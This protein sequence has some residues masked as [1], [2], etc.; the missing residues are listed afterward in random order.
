MFRVAW[1]HINRYEN[2]AEGVRRTYF[3]RR[4]LVVNILEAS[5]LSLRLF[6]DDFTVPAVKTARARDRVLGRKPNLLRSQSDVQCRLGFVWSYGM[7]PI[8]NP[9]QYL[10]L[11]SR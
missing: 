5:L 2:S 1:L 6:I 8:A 7:A 11:T 4:Q 9:A 3:R 10:R